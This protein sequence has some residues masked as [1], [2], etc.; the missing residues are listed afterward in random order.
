MTDT[1]HIVR[2]ELLRSAGVLF[3]ALLLVLTLVDSGYLPSTPPVVFG[4]PLVI[5][6]AVFLSLVYVRRRTSLELK[7]GLSSRTRTTLYLVGGLG[8]FLSGGALTYLGVTEQDI[9]TEMLGLFFAIL[10]IYAI[11]VAWDALAEGRD[12]RS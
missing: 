3:F 9:V 6:L 11:F 5:T 4:L 1:D 8:L 12:S 7:V 10:G 2:E